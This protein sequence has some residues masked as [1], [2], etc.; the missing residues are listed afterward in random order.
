LNGLDAAVAKIDPNSRRVY[1]SLK[2]SQLDDV[3]PAERE[4]AAIRAISASLTADPQRTGWHRILVALPAYRSLAA[5]GMAS[6]LRGFG[7]FMQPLCQAGCAALGKGDHLRLI[8]A[9]PTDGVELLTSDNETIRARTFLAPFSYIAVWTLDPK[10]L[11]VID[12]EQQLGNQKLA[13][14]VYKPMDPSNVQ[15]Y[16]A[17]RLAGVIEASIGE[18][19]TRSEAKKRRGTVEVGEVRDVT[20]ENPVP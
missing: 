3:A 2:L 4:A 20:S 6:K 11:T 17:S 10:T 9:E 15:Q 7:I 14:P 18:T 13:E 5:D 8:D 12:R 1:A 16:V 19:V